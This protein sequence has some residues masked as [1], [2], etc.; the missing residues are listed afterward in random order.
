MIVVADDLGFSDLGC[1]GSEI[2]TPNLDR[3]AGAGIRMSNFY[4]TPRCSPSRAS[5]LTGLHPHQT[6]VGILTNNDT[7]EGYRGDLNERCVTIAEILRTA[8]Y[9]TA[10]RGKW[11]LATD[12][13]TPNPAWPTFRGFDSFWGTLTG[14]GSYYQPGTLTRGTKDASDEAMDPEFFYTDRIADEAIAFLTGRAERA[15]EAP[16][17]LYIPFTAPHWPL[18][19]RAETIA[20]YENV[21]EA[22]WDAVR[23]SRIQRQI[24]LGLLPADSTLS[25]RDASVSAWEDEP[26]KAWQARRMQV[27]AA[28]VEELDAA[29]GRVVKTID[30][31]EAL[32]DTLFIF[33]SDN[34]ASDESVPLVELERFRQRTD[35]VKT[36]TK[37]G[38]AVRIGND[39]LV[40]PGPEDTY[41]SYGRSWANVSNTPFRLYK[42]WA[43]EGGISAPFIVHWP[44]GGLTG[45]R[46]IE[47]PYQLV[48]VMPTILEATGTTYPSDRDGVSVHPL[49]G[50][51]MLN[52]WLGD[53]AQPQRLWW[54]H[55]GNGAIH[56]GRWKLVRQ[57][58]WPWELYEIGDDRIESVNLADQYPEIVAD[59]AAEWESRC[60][61]YDVLPFERT[62]KRYHERGL[63]WKDAIG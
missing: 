11:H 48:N 3:L 62:L 41:G 43:H 22:G 63:S 34:G 26:E 6:G 46:I 27:Y 52:V 16:F 53:L 24:D 44:N 36:S 58:G 10:I 39:P 56:D 31:L 7:P 15:E 1:Y 57:Y 49:P 51:S 37:D 40:D 13:T 5:L 28:Q 55:V 50:G 61:L 54:E 14:C 20:H 42:L 19:A 2:S 35:I 60:D 21:Y 38:R 30:G 4:S 9:E 12:M 47:A 17:F 18:H 59:L 33:L 23:E 45:G 8:G 32:D 25:R 29:I